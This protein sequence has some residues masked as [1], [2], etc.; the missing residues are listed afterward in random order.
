MTSYLPYDVENNP[1][2]HY[3][4][5]FEKDVTKE[6]RDAYYTGVGAHS[7]ESKKDTPFPTFRTS[8]IWHFL[9][10]YLETDVYPN[11]TYSN[12]RLRLRFLSSEFAKKLSDFLEQEQI[13]HTFSLVIDTYEIILSGTNEI[14][15]LSKIYDRAKIF[16]GNF[17]NVLR[18]HYQIPPVLDFAR[19]NTS[20]MSAPFKNRAS[21]EGYDIILTKLQKSLSRNTEMY[22]TNIKVS[23]PPGF[24]I[25]LLARS[26]LSD[27]GYI[28]SNCTAVIDKGYRGELKVR[29]TKIDPDLPD[30]ELPFTGIQMVLCK[31]THYLV[32]EIPEKDI[33]DTSRGAGG[34][35]STNQTK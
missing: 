8:E 13:K 10:G 1:N 26:S 16:C 21:D 11:V 29:L 4:F 34:F 18:N 17:S 7:I 28:L 30:F 33:T 35:G 32:N 3:C 14:D 23:P 6:E 25:Q 9:R 5:N 15:F 31:S 19:I 24:Y 20:I 12:D 27:Y 2:P 22:H